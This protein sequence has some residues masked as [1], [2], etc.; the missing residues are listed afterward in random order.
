MPE[1]K[2]TTA[3]KNKWIIN[4]HGDF[5]GDCPVTKGFSF[6]EIQ[7]NQEILIEALNSI[8]C[9]PFSKNQCSKKLKT[10]MEIFFWNKKLFL[11]P[12]M[13]EEEHPDTFLDLTDCLKCLQKTNLLP[14][15]IFN[16]IDCYACVNEH[17]V[18]RCGC[19]N[20][21]MVGEIGSESVNIVDLV[22]CPVSFLPVDVIVQNW[23][24]VRAVIMFQPGNVEK[25]LCSHYYCYVVSRSSDNKLEGVLLCDDAKVKAVDGVDFA[26]LENLKLFFSAEPDSYV[27]HVVLKTTVESKPDI[28]CEK[29][30]H[31]LAASSVVIDWQS[32]DL[33]IPYIIPD[34]V[35]VP[36]CLFAWV[37]ENI[38]LFFN[39]GHLG[40]SFHEMVYSQYPRDADSPKMIIP[41][42][43]G[44][45][46]FQCKDVLYAIY[47][48]TVLHWDDAKAVEAALGGDT[49]LNDD[50]VTWS[51]KLQGLSYDDHGRSIVTLCRDWDVLVLE[52]GGKVRLQGDA[53]RW[54]FM[55]PNRNPSKLRLLVWMGPQYDNKLMG[56]AVLDKEIDTAYDNFVKKL[57]MQVLLTIERFLG[58]TGEMRP[59]NSSTSAI[60][61]TSSVTAGVMEI[62][63]SSSSSSARLTDDVSSSSNIALRACSGSVLNNILVGISGSSALALGSNDLSVEESNEQLQGAFKNLFDA[64]RK[65]FIS[66]VN[67]LNSVAKQSPEIQKEKISPWL[68]MYDDPQRSQVSKLSS[69]SKQKAYEQV[70]QE[71]GKA[72]TA[73]QADYPGMRTIDYFQGIANEVVL[74]L[75]RRFYFIRC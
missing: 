15:Y 27:S 58:L 11:N 74:F 47:V 17:G 65:V 28:T 61:E 29:L 3:A 56:A 4:S 73:I 75:Y 35:G 54:F 53:N 8:L 48:V 25:D 59:A 62:I 39:F 5:P 21:V 63:P 46:W 69:S 24:N 33:S 30:S 55:Q 12:T 16:C 2:S 68:D 52:D 44:F 36:D 1:I 66:I 18:F 34:N 19:S 31:C 42:Y 67:L 71:I 57:H 50:F 26:D 49:A 40:Y 70:T 14:E 22:R 10:F 37:L 23:A 51:E 7:K 38:S 20:S 41:P 60:Y 32:N 9:G 64:H 43:T 6:K 72:I 13:V 45:N